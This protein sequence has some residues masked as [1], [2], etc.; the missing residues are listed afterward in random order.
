MRGNSTLKGDDVL[1]CLEGDGSDMFFRSGTSFEVSGRTTGPYA[2]LVLWSDDDNDND[3]DFYSKMGLKAMGSIYTPNSQIEFEDNVVWETDCISIVAR[4]LEL[5][6]DSVYKS[7]DPSVNCPYNIGG[8]V[9]T[10]VR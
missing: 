2:G 1:I 9:P 8:G 3:H 7:A 4:E 5:D 10:L 6:N